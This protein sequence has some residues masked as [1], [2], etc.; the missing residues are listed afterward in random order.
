MGWAGE[1]GSHVVCAPS[2]EGSRA[3]SRF[4]AALTVI[5]ACPGKGT[6]CQIEDSVIT[7]LWQRLYPVVSS[8]DPFPTSFLKCGLKQISVF[9]DRGFKRF[10][11]S[12]QIVTF[13]Y[14]S[15]QTRIQVYT[16]NYW[17]AFLDVL[18][19]QGRGGKRTVVTEGRSKVSQRRFRCRD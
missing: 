18:R 16:K 5:I 14:Q 8:P 13:I 19:Y 17:A 9:R 10:H 3:L 2:F 1:H 15:H 6:T 4:S 7:L 12:S 11:L